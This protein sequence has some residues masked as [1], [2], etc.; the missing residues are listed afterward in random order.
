MES[1]KVDECLRRHGGCA[2]NYRIFRNEHFIV[3]QPIS[4]IQ[5]DF[6]GGP[7]FHPSEECQLPEDSITDESGSRLPLIPRFEISIN[8]TTPGLRR[9]LSDMIGQTLDL[10]RNYLAEQD[11]EAQYQTGE[12]YYHGIGV[13]RD[14]TEAAKW[15]RMAAEQG[16]AGAQ[17]QLGC[18]HAHAEGVSQDYA[19]AVRW[20]R[21]AAE[22]GHVNAQCALGYAFHSGKGV[23]QSDEHA[24]AWYRRAAEQGNQ[25]A[26]SNLGW[27]YEDAGDSENACER[28]VYYLLTDYCG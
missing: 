10:A 21:K 22:Q 23:A 19:E 15:Y 6:N 18:C 13:A 12:S 28:A 26:Q 8:R 1:A 5:A 25:F 27:Y 24:V 7:Y 4:D 11:I 17:F 14:H 2:D 3:I 20:Y 9:V 16:H